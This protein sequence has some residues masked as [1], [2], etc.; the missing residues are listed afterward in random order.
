MI[1]LDQIHL[2]DQTEDFGVTRELKNCLKTRLIVVQ[3]LLKFATF[4]VKDVDQD[5]DV[6]KYVIA[7]TCEIVFHE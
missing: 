2:V 7:L 6:S 4:H 1:P 3:V 5:F